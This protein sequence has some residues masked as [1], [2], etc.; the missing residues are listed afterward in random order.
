M[1]GH[2]KPAPTRASTHTTTVCRHETLTLHHIT[3]SWLTTSKPP[4]G[5]LCTHDPHVCTYSVGIKK[6]YQLTY[7]HRNQY[8]PFPLALCYLPNYIRQLPRQ[9]EVEVGQCTREVTKLGNSVVVHPQLSENNGFPMDVAP[10]DAGFIMVLLTRLQTLTSGESY[11]M[12]SML[13][14]CSPLCS[15]SGVPAITAE[16]RQG[17]AVWLSHWQVTDQNQLNPASSLV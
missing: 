13:F 5:Q 17:L 6:H 7:L 2:S 10:V 14:T 8:I 4:C 11:S 16:S 12:L 15:K 9:C 3:I 1:L